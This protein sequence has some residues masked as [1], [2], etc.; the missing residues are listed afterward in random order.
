[1][2]GC[3]SFGDFCDG[4][5]LGGADTVLKAAFAAIEQAVE[6]FYLFS[7]QGV[8]AVCLP[9]ARFDQHAAYPGKGLLQAL[10][11]GCEEPL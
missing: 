3:G 9:E 5:V 4:L 7:R 6:H 11:Q 8:V 2:T 10:E 1:M